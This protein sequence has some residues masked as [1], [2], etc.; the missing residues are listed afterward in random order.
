VNGW[1]NLN[2]QLKELSDIV[3]YKA[4]VFSSLD[5]NQADLAAG[6]ARD[7]SNVLEYARLE[8]PSIV[9]ELNSPV[10]LLDRYDALLGYYALTELGNLPDPVLQRARIVTQLY[11]DLIY[12]RDRI[13]ILLR[14]IILKE[15]KRF[16]QLKYLSEWLEIVGDNQFANKSRALRN[17][18][19]HG[20]WAYL[21]NY[22]GLVFYPENKPP[23]TRHE[24]MQKELHL[25]HG[26]LYG[27]QLVFFV[28]AREKL[29]K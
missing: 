24:L 11:F 26:L 13:L 7:L 5:L 14:Q 27:F 20:K 22:S 19:A 21:P 10:S 25:I 12:F 18:F 8:W 2:K 29:S 1:Q 9:E 6:L 16:R 15:P 23:Y 17:G 3:P 28:I 4:P